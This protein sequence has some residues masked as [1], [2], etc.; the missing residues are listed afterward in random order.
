MEL[1]HILIAVTDL[2]AAGREFEERHGH[3]GRVLWVEG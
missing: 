1:D 3:G 2:G